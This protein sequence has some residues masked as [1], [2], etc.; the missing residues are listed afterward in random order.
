MIWLYG[1]NNCGTCRQARRWLESAGVDF[2]WHDLVRHGIRPE[3]VANWL[4]KVGL[5]T[6]LNKQSKAWRELG[7][8]DRAS[9]MASPAEWMAARVR[10]I[11]RPVLH[12]GLNVLSGFQQAK[13]SA[14][15][16]YDPTHE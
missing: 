2:E 4:D 12:T 14:L 7:E 16:D 8:A 10:L 6:L 5:D 3:T 11:K 9:V 13:Y 15:L 1:I